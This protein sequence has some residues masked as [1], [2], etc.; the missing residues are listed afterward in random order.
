[1]KQ[2]KRLL[3]LNLALILLLT[4]LPVQALAMEPEL[5]GIVEQSGEDLYIGQYGA[6]TVLDGEVLCQLL[7]EHVDR[8]QIVTI[9]FRGTVELHGSCAGLFEFFHALKKQT[10]M[11]DSVLDTSRVT[12]M[13]NMFFG[14][15]NLLVAQVWNWDTSN[16]TDMSGMFAGCSSLWQLDLSGWDLSSVESM[17]GMFSGCSSLET[18]KL[19]Q[20]T[21]TNVTDT[22]YLFEGCTSLETLDLTG[23][24]L[25]G[26]IRA[27]SMFDGCGAEQILYD[28]LLWNDLVGHAAEDA[29]YHAWINEYSGQHYYSKDRAAVLDL[30]YDGLTYGTVRYE[31]RE[32]FSA[33]F[34]GF[35]VDPV[36]AG[37]R[38]L[39][40]YTAPTGGK[41]ISEGSPCNYYDTLYAHWEETDLAILAFYE[42]GK[43]VG[44]SYSSVGLTSLI[45]AIPDPL[46]MA[47][48]RVIIGFAD[49]T[50][51]EYP[52][53]T[54]VS[55]FAGT[56]DPQEIIK[57]HLVTEQLDP[58][59]TYHI[60]YALTHFQHD[61]TESKQYLVREIPDGAE[62]VKLPVHADIGYQDTSWNTLQAWSVQLPVIGRYLAGEEIE[63]R[64]H[65]QVFF[66]EYNG[67]PAIPMNLHHLVRNKDGTEWYKDFRHIYYEGQ[68]I[69]AD[70]TTLHN[71]HDYYY[72]GTNS[73]FLGWNTEKDGSGDWYSPADRVQSQMPTDL[74][75]K[76]VEAPSEPW[77]LLA[78][79]DREYSYEL[80]GRT[81]NGLP[82]V[83]TS[84]AELAID[85]AAGTMT[86]PGKTFHSDSGYMVQVGWRDR[87]GTCYELGETISLS[88]ARST[89]FAVYG[90]RITLDYNYEGASPRQKQILVSA[91]DGWMLDAQREGYRLVNWTTDPDGYNY[92]IT[93]AN[94]FSSGVP[95]DLVLY[96]QWEA[97]SS[98]GSTS[99]PLIH[100]YPDSD[101]ENYRIVAVS[102]SNLTTFEAFSM[103]YA[104]TGSNA[105]VTGF[106]DDSGNTYGLTDD[107]VPLVG[108]GE[109]LKLTA[110]WTDFTDYQVALYGNG[111]TT[112]D[113]KVLVV[114]SAELGTVSPE[115][116][117]QP[118]RDG[119]RQVGWSTGRWGDHDFYPIGTPIPME[120]NLILYAVYGTAVL[121]KH[122][123]LDGWEEWFKSETYQTYGTSI[124]ETIQSPNYDRNNLINR[125]NTPDAIFLGWN[126]KADG[127]GQWVRSYD[128]ITAQTPTELWAQWYE[129]TG[130]DYYV[131][132]SNSWSF[133][134]PE[135]TIVSVS[136]PLPETFGGKE[137]FYWE[138]WDAGARY[139][140]PGTVV[141][142]LPS[143][144]IL[145]PV[146]HDP[147]SLHYMI[148]DG[149]G[150]VRWDN[151]EALTPVSGKTFSSVTGIVSGGNLDTWLDDYPYE[152]SDQILV[153]WQDENG[154]RFSPHTKAIDV[155]EAV[156]P[157]GEIATLKAQWFDPNTLK[158][159]QVAYLANGGNSADGMGYFLGDDQTAADN[160]FSKTG[161][162][163]LGWNTRADGTGQWY[164]PGDA[165]TDLPN[166]L[167]YAQWGI[168]RVTYWGGENGEYVM[169][170]MAHRKGD[171]LYVFMLQMFSGTKPY[172]FNG[173]CTTRDG[174]GTWYLNNEVTEAMPVKMDLYVQWMADSQTAIDNGQVIFFA[175]GSQILHN[176]KAMG[177]KLILDRNP[178]GTV[179]LPD[180]LTPEGSTFAGW[181]LHPA[182]NVS[183]DVHF[184]F[185][186]EDSL[187]MLYQPGQRVQNTGEHSSFTA[188]YGNHI[189]Y[190]GNGGVSTADGESDTVIQRIW[191][192]SSG[193]NLVKFYPADTFEN[194]GREFLGWNTQ[195]D[196]TGASY[197][198]ETY[199]YL[200]QSK[201]ELY[202]QWEG[203][204]L[205]DFLEFFGQSLIVPGLS[206]GT[207]F[208]DV[209]PGDWFHEA[210]QYVSANGI[211][212]GVGNRKFEPH[213]QLSRAMV[214][215]I[216]YNQAGKPRTITT[217]G[218]ADVPADA[219]YAKAVSWAVK[220]GITTG[221]SSTA[222]GPN[223]PVTREQLAVFLYRYAQSRGPAAA[224]AG[225]WL[226][227]FADQGSVSAYA[228]E[229]MNWAVS[230]G[231]LNGRDGNL[232]APQGTATR[233]EAAAILMRY[234]KQF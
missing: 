24:D 56:E 116:L 119:L 185:S 86:L 216:L 111:G 60:Y 51:K 69:G 155:L 30:N 103:V 175:E 132:R 172:W 192:N 75:A 49:D 104:Q 25:S 76:A 209:Q 122:V 139:F 113:G 82:Y 72:Y 138:N 179:T 228:R 133:T 96:A 145:S 124:Y 10:Y 146:A 42:D 182:G 181:T 89:F 140:L 153:S 195:P 70:D 210:V 109:I 39:G 193:G 163:F 94:S 12:D 27:D 220:E 131:L 121:T 148:L 13:S 59:K 95:K 64:G 218:F 38:F 99:V 134:G 5:D 112:A 223:D 45:Q 232:L 168:T 81:L 197:T 50:G 221:Y 85:E 214:A 100:F 143:G 188:I 19:P 212:S 213:S 161:E 21:R 62:T 67:S 150:G 34:F 230:K 226:S 222:F 125:W 97:R 170:T 128:Y 108:R 129:P 233:A 162:R 187:G 136:D 35:P 186:N 90:Y 77:I 11:G 66:A 87:N 22:S 4:M 167:L 123:N 102:G 174:S 234:C 118:T 149:N 217:A 37:Y 63:V 9:T 8:E 23:L 61:S 88:R 98:S 71:P 54:L 199:S 198:P 231:L 93:G 58:D 91:H 43:H 180:V 47:S 194:D 173:W 178:D 110:R 14:C 142:D 127:S 114:Q 171:S 205:E 177:M 206:V 219:W 144:A 227:G 44:S 84:G 73:V 16:V 41:Q 1:M 2:W 147:D 157:N 190:H 68:Q 17:V 130:E 74:Y 78:G 48:S 15:D 183:F 201:L 164:D 31:N 53:T 7:Y 151:G 29:G 215:Q 83:L 36:R 166:T 176:G 107:V 211:M 115:A 224:P 18:L 154:N 33:C 202:A 46:L 204:D 120:D 160:P 207:D 200:H 65:N 6:T 156:S 92:P 117:F 20:N 225:D 189:L 106:T 55:T 229:A 137:I 184:T 126:T 3:C 40:W 208:T 32:Y 196:G 79:Y 57:V 158:D 52:L 135:N 101:S 28:P 159:G 26:V 191:T 169:Q 141:K 80:S 165:L 152:N 105:Y 203:S